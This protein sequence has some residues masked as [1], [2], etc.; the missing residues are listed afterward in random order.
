MVGAVEVIVLMVVA[1]GLVIVFMREKKNSAEL[2]HYAHFFW[3]IACIYSLFCDIG[4]VIMAV[5]VVL[6][7]GFTMLVVLVVIY[8][9]DFWGDHLKY[10]LLLNFLISVKISFKAP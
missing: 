10:I 5:L 1:L 6:R 9:A 3:L 7:L 4:V 8:S 2:R